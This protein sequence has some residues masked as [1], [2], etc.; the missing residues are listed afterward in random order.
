MIIRRT[1]PLLFVLPMA[2]GCTSR[3]TPAGGSADT[4]PAT[5]ASAAELPPGA[6]DAEARL[7]ASPRHAEWVTIRSASDSVRAYVV[8]PE[9][10]TPAPVVI[11]V[12]EIFAV[13]DWIQS[14]AD[15]LAADGFI[16]I[17]PDFLSGKPV[18]RASRDSVVAAVRALAESEVQQRIDL[19]ASYGMSLPAARR[20]YAVMGFCWGGSVAFTHATHAPSLGASV[21]YYGSSPAT[22]RLSSGRA[23]ILG[24]YG[25]DD[26]RVNATI[27]PADSTLRA[28]GRSFTY[29]IYPGAG[30][31]FLRQQ[32]GR[33]GANRAASERAWPRTIAFLRQHLES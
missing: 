32:T 16:A 18:N 3:S 27:A 20:R 21:V 24:L 26:Q 25:E 23:P 29:E 2:F 14:V 33:D 4:A 19:V 1:A 30:H 7:S 10:S 8:Y 6:E 12:H 9:R 5:T 28:L 31:G 22:D 13:S 15:Q 11:V 17:A